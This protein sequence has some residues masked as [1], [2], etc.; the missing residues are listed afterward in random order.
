MLT[1]TLLGSPF[2]SIDPSS[3]CAESSLDISAGRVRTRGAAVFNVELRDYGFKPVACH[4]YRAKPKGTVERAI[5]YLRG[6][7]CGGFS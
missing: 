3:D 2:P 7:F 6:S 4:P 5:S 1:K